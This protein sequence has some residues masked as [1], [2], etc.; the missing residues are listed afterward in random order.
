MIKEYY[1]SSS[2]DSELTEYYLDPAD[3]VEMQEASIE[4]QTP[5]KRGRPKIPE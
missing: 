3:E 5:S 1:E 2:N 4:S